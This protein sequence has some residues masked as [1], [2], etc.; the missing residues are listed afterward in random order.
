[1]Q[2]YPFMKC[3]SMS[4]L[5]ALLCCALLAPIAP[6]AAQTLPDAPLP[7]ELYQEIPVPGQ[8]GRIDHFSAGGGLVYFSLVGAAAIGIE[9]GFEGRVV[10]FLAHVP[11]PQG[12][13]YVPGFDQVF[14]ASAQG[15]VYVF[16]G[17]THRLEKTIPFGT[18]AD[19][20]R[21]DPVHRRVLVGFGDSDGGLASIDPATDRRVGP[22]LRTGSHPESFQVELHGPMIYVNCPHAGAVIEAIDRDTGKAS[23]WRLDGARGN[24]PMAL[25]EADHRLFTVTRR[26]P[27]LVVLDTVTGEQVAAVPGLV[28]ESDD[29]YFDPVRK[30]IYV[31]GGQGYVSVVQQID[32][33]RYGLISNVP[34][35]VGARTG[36]WDP[37]SGVLYVGAQAGGAAPA[38]ILRFQALN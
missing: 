37:R 4:R 25:D 1:M 26:P 11:E 7:L 35:R 32:P 12:V 29:V 28:A 13:L 14:A 2:E 21:W 20:L 18:D 30:R 6:V 8:L 33:D 34:T 17:K 38:Q 31:I 22:V 3:S 24:Y 27:M 10:G 23:K 36:Y 16:N 5:S 9:N 15:K 19:N